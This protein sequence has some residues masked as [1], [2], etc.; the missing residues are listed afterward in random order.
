MLNEQKSVAALCFY[1]CH[2]SN[3]R[4]GVCHLWFQGGLGPDWGVKWKNF[5]GSLTLAMT[6][7]HK[8]VNF[9]P[10]WIIIIIIIINAKIKVTLNKKML[11]GHFTKIIT[12]RCQ[13]AR[14]PWTKLS[15]DPGE[16]TAVTSELWST[17]VERSMHEQPPPG[18]R[19]QQELNDV[20]RV[21]S[22]STWQ[23]TGD[24]DEH[25]RRQSSVLTQ[26]ECM[27]K[28]WTRVRSL[29]RLLFFWLSV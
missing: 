10:G 5:I 9:Y 29:W 3:R 27:M 24:A 6:P 17:M 22:V 14:R 18:R 16:T 13:S 28:T 23:Q 7:L 20:L 4:S 19:G 15:S 2:C 1:Y 21:Q 26:H 25:Q 8:S 11:Q 12:T